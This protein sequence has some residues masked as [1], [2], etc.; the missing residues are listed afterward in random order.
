MYIHARSGDIVS[1]R[2]V[3]SGTL[4]DPV[5]TESTLSNIRTW[6]LQGFAAFTLGLSLLVFLTFAIMKVIY[7]PTK[8]SFGLPPEATGTLVASFLPIAAVSVV[9][10]RDLVFGTFGYVNFGPSPVRTP[11]TSGSKTLLVFTMLGPASGIGVMFLLSAGVARV[12]EAAWWTGAAA[13]VWGFSTGFVVRLVTE[14]MKSPQPSAN[15]S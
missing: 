12:E 5:C 2:V 8:A 6:H 1:M 15:A 3:S 10:L 14:Q 11:I 9:G 13:T 4:A 7:D